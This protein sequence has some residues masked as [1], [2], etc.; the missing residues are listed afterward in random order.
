MYHNSYCARNWKPMTC[1]YLKN[2]G[3]DLGLFGGRPHRG[4]CRTAC[5]VPGDTRT[6]SVVEGGDIVA[7]APGPP[8]PGTKPDPRIPNRYYRSATV[9]PAKQPCLNCRG[10]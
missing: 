8:L 2:N 3:C 4:V 7:D 10:L 1:V 9:T 5:P 6:F